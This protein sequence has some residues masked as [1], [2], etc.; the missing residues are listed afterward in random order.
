MY[1]YNK[2]LRGDYSAVPYKTRM[3]KEEAWEFA[4]RIMNKVY[5]EYC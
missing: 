3:N 1:F 4:E 2:I 5:L